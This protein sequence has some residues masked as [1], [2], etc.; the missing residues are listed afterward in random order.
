MSTLSK[1]KYISIEDYLTAE[2]VALEKHEYYNGIMH[3]KGGSSIDENHIMRNATTTIGNH[4]IGKS[5]EL[6]LCNLRICVE[7][8]LF[9]TYPDLVVFAIQSKDIIIVIILLQTRQ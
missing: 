8:N 3:E 1:G 2:E 4:L 9:F 5:C 6:F 7:A